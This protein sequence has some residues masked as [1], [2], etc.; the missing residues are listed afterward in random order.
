MGRH[1]GFPAIIL[2]LGA[3]ALQW[4]NYRTGLLWKTFMSNPD[5]AAG[6]KKRD[7]ETHKVP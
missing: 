6:L 4:L 2:A 3:T 7:G 1:L 5:S